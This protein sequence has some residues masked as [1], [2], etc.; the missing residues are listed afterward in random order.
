MKYQRISLFIGFCFLNIY[1]LNAQSLNQQKKAADTGG[2]Y[3]IQQ[4]NPQQYIWGLGYEIQSDAISSANKGLPDA[5]TS[6]PHD[7]VPSERDRFYKEMLTGFRYCRIAGGLYLRGTT[8]DQKELRGRWNSQLLELREMMQKAHIEGVS[9]EYWS[10]A[11]YWKANRKYTGRDSSENKLRCF[12]A[13]FKNDPVYKGDTTAFLKD[14]AESLVNDVR[15][16]DKNGLKVLF[17]GLQNEP[18]IDQFYS[19]CKYSVQEYYEVFKYVA[20]YIKAYNPGISIISDTWKQDFSKPIKADPA[21]RQYVDAWVWHQIGHDADE[22]I[23]KQDEY[24]KDTYGKP[25]FQNEYEYLSG[26]T[27]AERCINTVQNIMNWFTFVNSPTWYWIHALKPTYNEEATGYSLGFWRP[28]DDEK[29]TDLEKGHWKYNRFNYNAM[30][31]FLKY[32]PWDSRRYAVTEDVVRNDNRVMAFKTP[33]GKMVVVITNRSG[34]DFTF[35]LD[36]GVDAKFKRYRYSPYDAGA[37]NLG[38]PMGFFE[39]KNARI[40]LPNLTWE[41]LIQQ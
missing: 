35:N 25:V 24:L 16:L 14:F 18:P 1:T 41:F 26:G 11:P 13:G 7:L 8:P 34:S 39:G 22:V 32:M 10:P 36:V 30:A 33:E 12:A 5:Y 3:A 29:T 31:G 28:F 23:K 40:T 4:N 21:A 37:G 6:V 19:S 15:F 27:S 9:F 38:V 2:Y 17:W 20:P